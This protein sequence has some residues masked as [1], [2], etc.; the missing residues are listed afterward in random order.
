MNPLRILPFLAISCIFT[1]LFLSLGPNPVLASSNALSLKPRPILEDQAWNQE[2]REGVDKK[3]EIFDEIREEEKRESEEEERE[4]VRLYC[5]S[6]RFA[7][8][9]NNLQSW[10]VVP[11][12]CGGFVKK[13]MSER[14]YRS[15][16]EMVAEVAGAFARNVELGQD[17]MDAWIF[18]IDETLL[19]NLVYYEENGFGLELFNGNKF[20]EWVDLA[21][22][23]AISPFLKLY[24]EVL[25]MGF[26]VFLLTGRSESQR[27]TTIHNLQNSGFQNWD[28]LIMRGAADQGKSAVFYKSEK[29]MEMEKEGF[30]ILG[31]SGDQWSDL[32]GSSMAIRSFKLPNPMYYIP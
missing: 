29:R 25:E 15:D 26:K 3:I 22:A 18:D 10:K 2:S 20:D 28:R 16:L 5:E 31:N 6:W 13:Y 23:P 14:G 12:E 27:S 8:E 1:S 32:L 4:R 19:S 24:E 9:T 21:E 11:I 7:V 17:G 30:R